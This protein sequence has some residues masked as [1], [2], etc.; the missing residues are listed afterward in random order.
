M[1]REWFVWH[2]V[3]SLGIHAVRELQ[4]AN[5]FRTVVYLFRQS[6]KNSFNGAEEQVFQPANNW[7]PKQRSVTTFGSQLTAFGSYVW[8]Q[9]DRL[10]Q[11]KQLECLSPPLVVPA[12]CNYAG[13]KSKACCVDDSDLL[14]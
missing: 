11:L 8:V 10:R 1:F 9:P 3:D 5:P 14:M 2:L 6:F 12:I 7:H 13:R 4:S